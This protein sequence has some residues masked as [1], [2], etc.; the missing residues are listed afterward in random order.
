[1]KKALP[2]LSFPLKLYGGGFI[3]FLPP[4]SFRTKRKM[5]EASFL[6]LLPFLCLREHDLVD[7]S[8]PLRVREDE[9]RGFPF[10]RCL[11]PLLPLAIALADEGE[12]PRDPRRKCLFLLLFSDPI[13]IQKKRKD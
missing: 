4:L 1:M 7:R 11:F 5:D 8:L 3:P 13:A 9:C 6:P 2:P 10:S 12:L